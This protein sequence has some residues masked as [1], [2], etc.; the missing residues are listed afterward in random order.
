MYKDAMRAAWAEINITNLDFNIKKIKEKV[1]PGKKITAILKADAYGHGSV[2]TATVLRANGINSFGVAT[3]SEAVRLRKAGFLLEEIIVLYPVQDPFVD[4]IIKHRL[5]PV[6]CDYKNAEAISRAAQKENII[7]KGYIAVDTGMGRIGYNPD[8]STSIEDIKMINNLHNF[9][10]AGLLSHFAT[11]DEADKTYSSVQEQRY[12]V[13]YKKLINAGVPIPERTLANS[14][15]IMEIA[16][17]HYEMTRCG[18]ILYGCYPSGEV[19]RKQL[20]LRPAMSVKANIIHLKQVPAGTSISYGR[21]FTTT[22]DSLIATI[23][24]GYA[25]GL[26]RPYSNKGKV[27][28]NGVFAPI[29]GN[30]CMDMCMIDVTH[31]PYVRLGDEVTIMGKDGIYEITADDIAKA[32]DTINYEVVCGFGQRLPKVYVY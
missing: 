9:K 13:F 21:K 5:T 32:T 1:G 14:A 24:I 28:V 20:E 3:L 15:A 8:D 31:V 16:S 25:D 29:A 17:S 19:D 7:I 26:P 6:V 30:I 10:I 22:K 18:I 23:P 27:I 12:M 2:K 4:T 11:A